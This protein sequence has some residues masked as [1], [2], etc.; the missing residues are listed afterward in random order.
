MVWET[1]TNQLLLNVKS[2][3]LDYVLDKV[4]D[5]LDT[6]VDYTIYQYNKKFGDIDDYEKKWIRLHIERDLIATFESRTEH[7]DMLIDFN[8]DGN[9]NSIITFNCVI[10]RD[11]QNYT[12]KTHIVW[13]GLRYVTRFFNYLTKTDLEHTK[14]KDMTRRYNKKIIDLV[15]R[16]NFENRIYFTE[17]NMNRVKCNILLA[18]HKSD[19][20]I[21]KSQ[22]A[23]WHNM[24]SLTWQQAIKSG[25]DVT[26]EDER[27]FNFVKEEAVKFA[28]K[29]Y[30]DIHIIKPKETVEVLRNELKLL[31]DKLKTL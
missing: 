25:L 5:T 13:N 18:E 27:E 29:R 23:E 11:N 6:L 21:I 9:V 26:Y 8:V 15:N 10:R 17:L 28:L 7:S 19:S 12:F 31:K 16:K 20:D 2:D 30:K 1:K 22:K 14:R 4:Q 3:I 24:R